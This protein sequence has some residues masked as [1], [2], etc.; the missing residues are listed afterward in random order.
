MTREFEFVE[1]SVKVSGEAPA[2][3]ERAEM[4]HGE[5]VY[6]LARGI[7]TEVAFPETKNGDIKRVAKIKLE[8]GFVVDGD[9]AE[10][11]IA[12]ERERQS[13]QGNII[14]E[15]D[16]LGKQVAETAAKA[17]TDMNAVLEADDDD[18]DDWIDDDEGDDI[19]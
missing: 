10:V 8:K 15:L 14:A 19:E 2:P 6:F 18:D 3:P 7:V 9:G 4:D 16:R 17:V 5:E 1:S 12:A 13:G 11:L